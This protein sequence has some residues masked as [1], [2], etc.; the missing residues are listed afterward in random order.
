VARPLLLVSTKEKQ[1]KPREQNQV[2]ENEATRAKPGTSADQNEG[3]GSR[4]AD[5]H[6]REGVEKTVKSGR[7]EELG[8]EAKQA[9]EGE[10]GDELREAEEEAKEHGNA[11][12][13]GLDGK[14]IPRRRR[15]GQNA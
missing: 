10:E 2:S 15:P 8:E 7:V 6:Y 4:S 13:K 14:H 9:L 12:P 1:M 3:E 5:R 11:V